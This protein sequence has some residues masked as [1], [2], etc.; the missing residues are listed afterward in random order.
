MDIAS[1]GDEATQRAGGQ[2]AGKRP[3]MSGEGSRSILEQLIQQE[4]GRIA[5]LP[6]DVADGPPPESAP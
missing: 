2:A 3:G 4:K 1:K 6:R 5:Q